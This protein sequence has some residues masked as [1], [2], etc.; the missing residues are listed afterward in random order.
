[1]YETD[2]AFAFILFSPRTTCHSPLKSSLTRIV[3]WNQPLVSEVLLPG[4]VAV[5]LTVGRGRNATQLTFPRLGV[6][7][8]KGRF[9]QRVKDMFVGTVEDN[10]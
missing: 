6:N 5:D 2:V 10:R 8:K 7:G 9:E 3:P 4:D 1:L